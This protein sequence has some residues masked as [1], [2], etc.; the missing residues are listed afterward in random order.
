VARLELGLT[1]QP[2]AVEDVWNVLVQRPK[3][4][5]QPLPPGTHLSTVFFDEFGG[6]LLILGAPGTGTKIPCQTYLD[7]VYNTL[8]IL[9]FQEQR[10]LLTGCCWSISRRCIRRIQNIKAKPQSLS[11]KLT[12]CLL[13]SKHQAH[14]AE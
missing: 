11:E 10:E 4:L 3:Q 13:H 2:D 14:S 12:L 7:L 5:L 6:T 8:I 1:T 9:K